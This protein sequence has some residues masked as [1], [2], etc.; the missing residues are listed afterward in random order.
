MRRIKQ[1]LGLT[2]LAMLALIGLSQIVLETDT[3]ARVGPTLGSWGP[4][5]TPSCQP[6]LQTQATTKDKN[7]CDDRNGPRPLR[8][9]SL[10]NLHHSFGR[11][12]WQTSIR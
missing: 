5:N 3:D 2:V 12:T 9:K 4:R 1:K 6:R 8:I 10:A 7:F 11:L